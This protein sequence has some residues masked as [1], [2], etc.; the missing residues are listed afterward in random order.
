MTRKGAVVMATLIGSAM[1]GTLDEFKAFYAPGTANTVDNIQTVTNNLLK[2]YP[3][4]ETQ[5]YAFRDAASVERA[6]L[7]ALKNANEKLGVQA[8][9]DYL[10]A[11]GGK[12]LIDGTV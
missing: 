6:S 10:A 5:I 12:L 3:E 2:R 7:T 8:A 11:H 1:S 9:R 4:F